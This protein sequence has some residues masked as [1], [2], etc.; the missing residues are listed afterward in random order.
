M[1]SLFGF[2]STAMVCITIMGLAFMVILAMPQSRMRDVMKHVM[3]AIFSILYVVSP[4][5]FLPEIVLGPVGAVD[6]IAAAIIG[7]VSAKRAM[8]AGRSTQL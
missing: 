4:I 2:L 1:S 8:S 5:D 6:D 7:I 3:V